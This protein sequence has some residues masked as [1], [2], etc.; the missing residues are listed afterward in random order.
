MDEQ[1]R[2]IM[3][4]MDAA[5]DA[6]IAKLRADAMTNQDIANAVRII[7]KWMSDNYRAAGYKRLSKDLIT[8]YKNLGE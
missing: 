3:N 8:L 4:Q 6:A 5:A 1:Q 7:G 2:A